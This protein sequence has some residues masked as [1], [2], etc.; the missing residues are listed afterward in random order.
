MPGEKQQ[1]VRK[2]TCL[3]KEVSGVA[4]SLCIICIIVNGFKAEG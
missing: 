1:D 4:G 3:L 2:V